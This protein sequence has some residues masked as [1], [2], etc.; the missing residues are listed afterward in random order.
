MG[1]AVSSG[2]DNADDDEEENDDGESQAA[3][4]SSTKNT[5]G[6]PQFIFVTA[7]LPE[8]VLESITTEFSKISYSRL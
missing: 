1:V 3:S 5:N 6:G 4:S 2:N 8:D 7:T